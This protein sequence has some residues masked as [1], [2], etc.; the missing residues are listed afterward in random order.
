M[1]TSDD[2][3]YNNYS[4]FID[5]TYKSLFLIDLKPSDFLINPNR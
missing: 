1:I 5:K 4:K 2:F 3:I